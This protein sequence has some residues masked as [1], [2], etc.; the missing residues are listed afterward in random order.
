MN[1]MLLMIIIMIDDDIDDK[2]LANFGAAQELQAVKQFGFLG[3]RPLSLGTPPEFELP[4]RFPGWEFGKST[5]ASWSCSC[6]FLSLGIGS[7]VSEV[8]FSSNGSPILCSEPG[9]PG[10]YTRYVQ[11]TTPPP[12]HPGPF[13]GPDMKLSNITVMLALQK[14]NNTLWNLASAYITM[15]WQ[16][17]LLLWLEPV[18]STVQQGHP[19]EVGTFHPIH[20]WAAFSCVDTE[21][22]T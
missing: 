4:T 18:A 16:T 7:P 11:Q 20:R 8:V 6:L 3:D 15:T 21:E 2:S 9:S 14:Q 10:S 19:G 13:I 12:P 22:L 1:Q 5:L 17:K